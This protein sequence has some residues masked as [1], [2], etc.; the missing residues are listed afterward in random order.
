MPL[1]TGTFISD[2]VASNPSHSDAMSQSDSHAR[3]IKQ[4]ILNTF[5]GITG[6][7]TATHTQLNS[8]VGAVVTG[9][10]AALH[11]AGTLA[12][13]SVTF[14]G[15]TACG[16][17]ASGTNVIALVTN[18]VAAITISAAQAVAIAGTLTVASLSSSGPYSGGTGQLIPVGLPLPWLT[19]T[20]PP[21]TSFI[22]LN[23][24]A[25]SRT[26]FPQLFALWGTRFG[27][28]DGSTTFNVPDFR[29]V[30]PVG[31]STIGGFGDRGL[32][33]ASGVNANIGGVGNLVGEGAHTLAQAELPNITPT[34][35]GT[36]V[37]PTASA[38]VSGAAALGIPNGSSHVTLSA[39]SDQNVFNTG[40]YGGI[41]ITVSGIT[42]A[43]SITSINGNQT[44]QAHNTVQPGIVCNWICLAA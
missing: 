23:S 4:A 17:Y 9:V 35:S 42:P 36:P 11:N 30:V 24:Q 34:F 38:T 19:D 21:G 43:G 12:A 6:A 44:E 8:A 10:N 31:K 25:I 14:I 37:T 39:G 26:T 33:T 16:L 7:V 27:A 29:D 13:P 2:F 28:G 32:I 5:T 1:E 22:W 41:A 18:G 3:W 20:L 40:D 15:N